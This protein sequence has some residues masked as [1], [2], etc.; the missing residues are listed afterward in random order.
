M[1][2]NTLILVLGYNSISP[3]PFRKAY[4]NCPEDLARQR[5]Q[6]DYPT[7]RD[8]T[9]EVVH[10]DDEFTIRAGGAISAY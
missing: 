5:F 4:L 6:R 3:K 7:I 1:A 9:V 10:F 8:M 2:T